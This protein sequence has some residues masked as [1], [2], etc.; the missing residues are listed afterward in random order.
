MGTS[1]SQKVGGPYI[2]SCQGF[3]LTEVMVA[4]MMSAAIIAAGLGALTVTQKTSRITGQIV[5]TQATARNAIDMI[6]ADLKLAGFGMNGL[7][8]GGVG[9]CLIN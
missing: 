1:K 8:G 3:T 9:N 2:S 5:D 6:T 4:T 7:V